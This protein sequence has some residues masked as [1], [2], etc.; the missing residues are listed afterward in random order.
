MRRDQSGIA[1]WRGATDGGVMRAMGYDGGLD[2]TRPPDNA[3]KLDEVEAMRLLA[4]AAY[5]RVVFTLNALPAIRPVN[6]L[7]DDGTIIIRTRL[8]TAIFLFYVI[9]PEI[10]ISIFLINFIINSEFIVK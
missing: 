10:S 6:H 3:Q 1:R 5:G 7:V 9:V 8:T 4:T 2:L